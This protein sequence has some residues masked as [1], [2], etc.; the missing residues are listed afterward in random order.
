[1]RFTKLLVLLAVLMNLSLFSQ[2]ENDLS[3]WTSILI[4]YEID[5]NWDLGLEGQ[6]RLKSNISTVDEYFS[7][8]SIRRKLLKGLRFGLAFRY[9]R[10]NDDMGGVQGYENHFRYHLDAVYKHKLGDFR[11][12]YRLR[13]Q[14]KDELG[15]T[16]DEGD[17]AIR[18]LRFKTGLE[19][20]IKKWPLDPEFNA[21]IFSRFEKNEDS[22][23]DKYRLTLRTS[24]SLKK[25][26]SLGAYYRVEGDIA[27]ES[28]DFQHIIGLRYKYV[29]QGR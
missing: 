5:D 3:N 9:I 7:E 28:P 8:F 6:L 2:A 14:N 21:E 25:A 10:E 15:I 29:F 20:K 22:E 16:T 19:Y 12:G 27:R 26:G 18:R 11:F 1:M 23:F 4:R 24:Y 13:F 17:F